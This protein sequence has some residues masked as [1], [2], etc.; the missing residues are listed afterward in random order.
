MLP[1]DM[2]PRPVA[3]SHRKPSD[4]FG[5][6]LEKFAP[7]E[8]AGYSAWIASVANFNVCVATVI[9]QRGAWIEHNIN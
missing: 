6:D 1:H 5:G 8:T 4:L 3:A 7:T 9:Q 2:L